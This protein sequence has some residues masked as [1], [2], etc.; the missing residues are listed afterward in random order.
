MDQREA[1]QLVL[2]L[3]TSSLKQK[4]KKT[5]RSCLKV[6]TITGYWWQLLGTFGSSSCDQPKT[7]NSIYI[8]IYICCLPSSH[9]LPRLNL[10][11]SSLRVTSDSRLRGSCGG[12]KAVM[13]RSYFQGWAHWLQ[14][15]RSLKPRLKEQVAV[16]PTGLASAF[17]YICGMDLRQ[18][19]V[20]LGIS[21]LLLNGG[22]SQ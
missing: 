9:S 10:F 16:V 13:S 15:Q 12:P 1:E 11:L 21:N 3:M 19:V 14:P 8:Y 17:I 18:I 4:G 22:F 7:G 20:P 6:N 2:W 5:R